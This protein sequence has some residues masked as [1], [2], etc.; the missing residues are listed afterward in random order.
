MAKEDK[1]ARKEVEAQTKK[2][3]ADSPERPPAGP[4]AKEHLIDEAKTP[5]AGTL[6]EADEESVDPGSG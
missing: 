1:K 5:G 2:K 4:R 6:P 3:P